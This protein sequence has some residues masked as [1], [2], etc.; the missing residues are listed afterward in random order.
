MDRTNIRALEPQDLAQAP[1]IVV[2][3]LSFISLKTVLPALAQCAAPGADLL[4]MV[5]PQ[6]EVGRERLG[7]GGVVKSPQLRAEAVLQV[8]KCSQELGLAVR[9][10][11]ASPL[12]GTSGNVE[13]FLWLVKI[14]PSDAQ[15]DEIVGAS[16]ANLAGDDLSAAI[17]RAIV[18]GPSR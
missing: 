17:E 16:V 15:S 2:S 10:V 9:D 7:S 4:L 1:E 11:V 14:A 6:F 12:P 8:A 5:K 3:D 18:E 13:Y